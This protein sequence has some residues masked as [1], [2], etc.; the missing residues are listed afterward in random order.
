MF[1]SWLVCQRKATAKRENKFIYPFL[2]RL[3]FF[4][5]SHKFPD[6]IR[7]SSW[8]L[9]PV[10]SSGYFFSSLRLRKHVFSFSNDE[11]FRI[12]F[13]GDEVDSIRT[14]DIE[15]Q[16][17]KEKLKKANIMPNVENKTLQEKRESFLK[18]ISSKTVIFAKNVDII[19]GN[20]DK[21]FAKAEEA[22]GPRNEQ[23]I[24]Q[25][26]KDQFGDQEVVEGAR[27]QTQNEH[28]TFIVTITKVDGNDVT[29]DMNHPLAGKDLTFDIEVLSVREA[30]ADE[31][32]HGHI[33]GPGC[34][35]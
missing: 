23:L 10:I 25:T 18:Y 2:K 21:F 9:I 29:V 30:T 5:I 24:Q 15:T 7:A 12:E 13:F 17:S 16:L 6:K 31:L 26:T 35:H 33:H 3:I 22:F 11:P 32:S 19:A 27:F 14:F 4:L 34:N 28:G 8:G 1:F 20:L